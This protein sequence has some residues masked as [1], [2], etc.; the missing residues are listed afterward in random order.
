MNGLTSFY[1]SFYGPK[2]FRYFRRPPDFEHKG[3]RIQF[4][5]QTPKE[6]FKQIQQN[7]GYQPCYIQTYDHGFL[8]NLKKNIPENIVFNRAFFDFDIEHKESAQIKKKLQELRS[9]GLKHKLP[10]QDALKENLRDLIIEEHIAE[11]AINDAKDFSMNFNEAFREYPILFFS[12]CKGCHAYTLFK[13]IQDVDINLAISEF[14]KAIKDTYNYNT[15]D[16]SVLKDSKS[17]LSRVPYSKH[18]YTGLTVVSFSIN[19]SYDTIINK[20]LNPVV[21]SFH[22]DNYLS[23]F[24]KHLEKIDSI[25]KHNK[26]IKNNSKKA[27]KTIINEIKSFNRVEDHRD[28]FR[29]VIGP[30]DRKYPNKKYVMYKCPFPDHP[31][32]NPSFMVYKKGYKCYGCERKG[33][34]WQFLKDYNGWDDNQIKAYL[35]NI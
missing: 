24:G 17:R 1:R 14:G 25:L 20:S 4:I 31:D 34:F 15:L 21:E 5:V 13:P 8:G 11:P 18:Q 9:Q 35:K 2:F 22:K 12:G 29:D 30:P 33:N 19:D 26:K 10:K 23:T 6:L 7:S 32:N 3:F 28:F 27:K 16:L